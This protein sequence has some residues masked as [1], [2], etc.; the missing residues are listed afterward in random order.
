MTPQDAFHQTVHSY[1]GGC[2]SLAPRLGMSSAVLRNKANIHCTTN[3]PTLADVDRVLGITANY[4]VLH[5]LASNHNHVCIPV[6]AD[7]APSDLA[8]LELVTAVWRS[9]G[10]VGAA[11]DAALADG[12][13]E[14]REVCRIRDAIYQ[15]IA[16]LQQMLQRIAQLQEP[17]P[18]SGAPRS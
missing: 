17:A 3:H 14:A 18:P 2:E 13:I 11:V 1:P 6:D 16:G 12:R 7:V 9:H 15:H 10:D 4:S 5:A 8:V